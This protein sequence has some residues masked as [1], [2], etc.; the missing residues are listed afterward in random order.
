MCIQL[1][2]KVIF[3]PLDA[4]SGDDGIELRECAYVAP[5]RSF[6]FQFIGVV[7]FL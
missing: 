6:P 7:V 2:G 3:C 1:L 5:Q 4:L